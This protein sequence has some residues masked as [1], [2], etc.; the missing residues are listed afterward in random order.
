[1]HSIW[2][3][4]TVNEIEK[5]VEWHCSTCPAVMALAYEK[6][7]QGDGVAARLC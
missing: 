6:Q 7:P 1:M 3:F 2:Q 5:H 4:V